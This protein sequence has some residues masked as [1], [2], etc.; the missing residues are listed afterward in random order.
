MHEYAGHQLY[1]ATVAHQV[2]KLLGQ[3]APHVLLI[4][5]LEVSVALLMKVDY[6]R[7]DLAR[8]E[9]LLRSGLASLHLLRA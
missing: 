6:Q 5:V 1:K 7:H 2:G 9:P 4:V 8:A 3:I